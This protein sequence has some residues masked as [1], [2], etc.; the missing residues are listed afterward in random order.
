MQTSREC[1]WPWEYKQ[2]AKKYT[3]LQVILFYYLIILF[4][5]TAVRGVHKI[6]EEAKKL[7]KQ[8]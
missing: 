8:M 7:Q 3:T 6:T 5:P 4:Q 2:Y 1:S